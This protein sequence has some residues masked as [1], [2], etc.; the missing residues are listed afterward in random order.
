[1]DIGHCCGANEIF[2]LK[3]ARK[4]LK[5]YRRRGPR[6]STGKLLN[7]IGQSSMNNKTLLDIGGGIG[8]IQWFFLE[9]GGRM[10]TDVDA[11]GAYLKT[12]KEYSVEMGWDDRCEF[13]MGDFVEETLVFEIHDFVTLDK[14]VCCYPEYRLLLEKAASHCNETL[15]L[16]FPVQNLV[17]RFLTLL[18]GFYFY[19]KNN[20]FRTYIHPPSEIGKLIQSCGFERVYAGISFPWHVQIYRRVQSSQNR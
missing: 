9:N 15:A 1:M 6:G 14:V 16:T 4:Q 20:P 19:F 18:N 5:K 10:T 12:A 2:D 8:A 11:S 3:Q 17:S 13:M 7:Q